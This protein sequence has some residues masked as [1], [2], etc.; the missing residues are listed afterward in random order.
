[1]APFTIACN[2]SFSGNLKSLSR[3]RLRLQLERL[4]PGGTWETVDTG[5]ITYSGAPG[6]YRY[7][8]KNDDAR[9]SDWVMDFR[10]PS[11]KK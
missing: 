4:T 7:S 2:G 9:G 10:A 8:I 3:V 11:H 6:T 5:Y 1:M